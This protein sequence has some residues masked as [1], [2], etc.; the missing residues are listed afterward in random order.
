MQR[1]FILE[2]LQHLSNLKI[3][4]LVKFQMVEACFLTIINRFEI[5]AISGTASVYEHF[6]FSR[7][8]VEEISG[9]R[10]SARSNVRLQLA[11]II[12]NNLFRVAASSLRFAGLFALFLAFEIVA[13]AVASSVK[14][15][16]AF[17]G[18]VIEIIPFKGASAGSRINLIKAMVI[19]WKQNW[20]Q[21]H[22]YVDI[23]TGVRTLI[24]QVHFVFY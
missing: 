4:I 17:S 22:R 13:I 2:Q 6:A 20:Y 16:M 11:R 5:V 12:F 18:F 21:L 24:A 1:N 10:C 14:E 3:A 8:A 23:C 7:L 15:H 19:F 9:Q